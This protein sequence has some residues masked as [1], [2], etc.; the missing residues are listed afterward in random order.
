[1]ASAVGGAPRFWGEYKVAP[2]GDGA[3]APKGQASADGGAYENRKHP[4]RNWRVLF[5]L[6]A[7]VSII[8]SAILTPSTAAE[9]IPPA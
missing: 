1:M 8:L 7:M 5:Y 9:T 6:G 4:S 3:L 2:S